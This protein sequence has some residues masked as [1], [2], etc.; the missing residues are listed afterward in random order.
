MA[1]HIFFFGEWQVS[2][3]ANTLQQG[4]K[5]RQLE[6]K[7][8][9]VLSYL[10]QHAGDVIS[11]D[12]LLEHCWAGIDTGDN[13][14]HKTIAQL[15][16][17]LDDSATA[18]IYIETIRKRGY[19]T[20]AEV[21]FPVGS[22][23]AV[24]TTPAWQGESP[25][26]GLRAF[27]AEDAEVFF[28]RSEQIQ[29][30]LE[31]IGQQVKYGRDFC[32]VLGPSGSG[33]S[34][35]INAG[36]MPNLMTAQGA[37][38]VQL[39]TYATLDMADVSGDNL[40]L[41]LGSAMLDWEL[42]DMPVLA[43]E[44]ADTLASQLQQDATAVLN[45]LAAHTQAH[46]HNNCRFGL[47]IDRLEV[48]LSSPAF[49]EQQRQQWIDLLEQLATCGAVLLLSACRNEFYPQLVSYQSLRAGKGRGAHFDLAPPSRQELL[50]M[51]RL[52]AVAAGLSW[53]VDESTA[54]PL[55]EILCSEAANYPDALPML[56]YMLQQLYLNRADDG[57]MLVSVYHELGELEGAIG[58]TA[59]EAIAKLSD[60]QRQALPR[61]LSLLVTLRE[62][63]QSVT[64][65]S[66]LW[67]QLQSDSE[68]ALVEAMVERRL[69][70]SQLH[71][72][73]PSFHIAHEA[74]LRR[75]S[76]AS[77]WIEQHKEMLAQQ[78]RLIHSA[79]RWQSEQRA[80]AYLLQEGKPL[81][82]AKQL[83]DNPLL[84]L[85]D[86]E[87]AFIQ[88]SQQRAKRRSW[89]RRG[90]IATLA[91]L[92]LI[93]VLMSARS[94]DAEQQAN[95]RRLDAENL[96]G[97]MVGD[98]ADKLRSI[99]RMDLLDGISSKALEY[100]TAKGNIQDKTLGFEGRFQHGQTLEL[101]GEV[102]YSRGKNDE[103]KN[104]LLAAEQEFLPLLKQ[105]PNNLEL[106]KSLGANA[107][108]QGQMEYDSSVWLRAAKHFGDYLF[109]SQNMV[110]IE[111]KN[112]DSL[113]EL[114]YANS[115]LG[116]V[117]MKLQRYDKAIELFEKA[118]SIKEDLLE[119]NPHDEHLLA[120]IA[121][122]RSW[123]AN[124]DDAAG[125]SKLSIKTLHENIDILLSI[126][127]SNNAYLLDI[128][129]NNQRLLARY[130]NFLKDYNK[131]YSLFLESIKNK[132]EALKQDPNNKI[133]E[134]DIE[135]IQ[136]EI[137]SLPINKNVDLYGIF[138]IYNKDLSDFDIM[139]VNLAKSYKSF[140]EG[141]YEESIASSKKAGEYF[142]ESKLSTID[143]DYLFYWIS[144][145]LILAQS[146]KNNLNEDEYKN[147]IDIVFNVLKD[148]VSNDSSIS[149]I[150]PFVQTCYLLNR[151]AE[152]NKQIKIL[153]KSGVKETVFNHYM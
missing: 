84:M 28:G 86:T 118:L 145:K 90:T 57:T 138:G 106:L 123:V 132:K 63:E 7:A 107:F 61:V 110:D 96:L 41:A 115:S 85:D 47:F 125:N 147:I 22:E 82:D 23:Q 135:R 128:L 21:R 70:V 76:R 13:P 103:A 5:K 18:P 117:E 88:A 89:L 77:E 10:C 126:K 113:M 136:L 62:D 60:N 36:I 34:S 33:K 122:T 26:P 102:A 71:Q 116:S 30:L 53:Q 51:I 32:L 68:R 94:I 151:Y 43:G 112:Y 98:F 52:P 46:R 56:Q 141:K 66:A 105:Q 79:S 39:L 72:G 11:S 9:D 97:F 99:G 137:F 129:S 31:R 40:W 69:F 130:Y 92:T 144:S 81:Q 16:R 59:E 54:T 150:L 3:V 119:I 153:K 2:P 140:Y 67:Q 55:D 83:T 120:D 48:L 1:E 100:F 78:A 95:A 64:S 24:A 127:T 142:D 74:L 50:Q 143:D 80:S 19:R 49:D 111:P 45:R 104:A 14:L 27:S 20:L 121:D 148:K 152:C 108:W 38:G 37:Y 101:I 91:A 58:V 73:E 17:A 124:A 8:M 65:R 131:S 93:S 35:L 12:E 133:W 146:L 6:P 42:D 114:S 29:L 87:Q 109:F 25:F 139:L 75:W 44:S 15:R 134:S 4:R 149:K